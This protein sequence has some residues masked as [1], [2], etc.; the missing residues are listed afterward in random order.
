MRSMMKNYPFQIMLIVFCLILFFFAYL[1]KISERPLIYAI[2]MRDRI[3]NP[4][5]FVLYDLS[6]YT[7]CLW[8]MIITMTT[9][10][11][12]DY[13]PETISGRLI[14]VVACFFGI[15]TVSLIV[16]IFQDLFKLTTSEARVFNYHH[17][18]Y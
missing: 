12:G 17:I 18:K 7:N 1:L 13:T 2:L 4:E 16:I 14:V 5:F 9:V 3:S 10:G 11:Y 6:D 8:L 15:T